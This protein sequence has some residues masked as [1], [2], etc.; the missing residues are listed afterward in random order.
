MHLL[1]D[2][3]DDRLLIH[4]GPAQIGTEMREAMVNLEQQSYGILT[5]QPV[6]RGRCARVRGCGRSRS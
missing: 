4:F 5:G 3:R 1:I 2:G 6:G